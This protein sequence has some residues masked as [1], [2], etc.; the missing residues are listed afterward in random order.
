MKKCEYM[1]LELYVVHH[2]YSG[3][4]YLAIN[5]K[6]LKRKPLKELDKYIDANRDEAHFTEFLLF[7]VAPYLNEYGSQGW[8]VIK[9]DEF[10][11]TRI[12]VLMEKEYVEEDVPPEE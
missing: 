6:E 3:D 1:S 7:L 12:T 9:I 5:G 2:Q 8:K 10:D 4:A 11:N